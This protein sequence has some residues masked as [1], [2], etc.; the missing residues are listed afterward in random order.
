[1]LALAVEV[2]V[3]TFHMSTCFK[4]YS[5]FELKLEINGFFNFSLL[6]AVC[7]CQRSITGSISDPGCGKSGIWLLM[8]QA[9]RE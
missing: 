6:L 7:E 1:V 9:I 5:S 3:P 4:H 8:I 2:C